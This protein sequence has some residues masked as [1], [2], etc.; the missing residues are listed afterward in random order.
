[1]AARKIIHIDMDAF[2]ASVEQRDNPELKGRPVIVGGTP[3]QRGVVAACSYEARKFGIRSAMATATAFR[4]CP[5]CVLVKPDFRK[6]TAASDQIHKIFHEYTDLVE[7]VS[8]DE[9]YLD[10]TENFKEIR[11][12]TQIAKEIK[13]KIY[14]TTRLTASAGVSYCKFLAKIASGFKKPDGLTVVTPDKAQDFIDKLPVGAFHGVGKVTEKYMLSLNI[15]N[16]YDLRQKSLPFLT[17]HFGK[18]GGWFH[19][20][21]RGIDDSPVEPNWERKSVGREV[22]LAEDITDM[23]MIMDILEE[24][25]FDVER[26]MKE[27]DKKGRTITLKVKYFD[28]KQI[29]RSITI[30]RRIQSGATIFRYIKELVPKTEAGKKKIRL[31]GVSMHG[32]EDKPAEIKKGQLDLPL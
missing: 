4:L 21:A 30:D 22:T 26:D 24:L 9:A 28:F 27:E 17:E 5:Q 18:S 15:K 20:L 13:A 7:P 3:Q 8:L 16:G 14:E 10:V 31:L 29:T 11:S 19:D 23:K 6:Y 12:A 32:F 25:C 2:Y 1:M